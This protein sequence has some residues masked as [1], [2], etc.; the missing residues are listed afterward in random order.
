MRSAASGSMASATTMAAASVT[1]AQ[2]SPR[3]A[4]SAGGPPRGCTHSRRSHAAPG[5]TISTRRRQ[6]GAA[7]SSLRARR[8]WTSSVR[9]AGVPQSAGASHS[10]VGAS[11][12]ARAT[13]AK[14][15]SASAAA[16]SARIPG[17]AALV[18]PRAPNRP[19]TSPVTRPN[20]YGSSPSAA[21]AT[22]GAAA[23]HGSGAPGGWSDWTSA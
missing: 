13:G 22:M 18:H 9:P 6:P 5:A 11:C 19:R 1:A 21:A 20:D 7:S 23:V 12:C 16:P 15:T 10:T 8:R 2:L 17:A 14:P 3:S 4:R